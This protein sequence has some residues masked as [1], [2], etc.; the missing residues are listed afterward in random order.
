MNTRSTFRWTLALLIGLQFSNLSSLVA[1]TLPHLPAEQL[2]FDNQRL[3]RVE[4]LAEQGI[5]EG[6]MPGCVICFGRQ[7]KIAYLRAFGNKQVQP[8]SIPMTVDTVFDMA[9]ITKPVATGT[10]VMKLIEEGRLRLGS[11]VVDFFP[12]FGNNGKEVITV[13]D[14]LIHQSGLIPDNPL[15]DYLEG[16]EIAWK[17]ICELSL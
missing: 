12:E 15:A 4:E 3:Q 11:K 2:G 5:R 13:Q 16:P 6:K 7:G 1:Q 9:S 8:E 10:S 14:L 17:K